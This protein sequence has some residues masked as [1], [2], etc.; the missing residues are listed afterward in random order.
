MLSDG[1]Q[2]Q[3]LQLHH[4]CQQ[5]KHPENQ[6]KILHYGRDLYI[7]NSCARM[8]SMQNKELSEIFIEILKLHKVG[9]AKWLSTILLL[10]LILRLSELRPRADVKLGSFVFGV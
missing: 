3:G 5:Q 10:R 2:D 1:M 6:N 7:H 8:T 9:P 4:V